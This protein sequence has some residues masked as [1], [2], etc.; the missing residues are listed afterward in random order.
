M[1]PSSLEGGLPRGVACR[2]RAA[3]TLKRHRVADFFWVSQFVSCGEGARGS[4]DAEM[5]VLALFC[6]NLA[7]FGSVMH[8]LAQAGWDTQDDSATRPSLCSIQ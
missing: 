3:T 7:F 6:S 8:N 1:V 4:V 2:L 5:E